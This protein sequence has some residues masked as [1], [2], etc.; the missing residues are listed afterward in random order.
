MAQIPR[1]LVT[2]VDS[3]LV[4]QAFDVSE[5]EWT[6]NVEHHHQADDLRA[7][8]VYLKGRRFV[9]CRSYPDGLPR[10]KSGS[11]DRSADSASMPASESA[12]TL[13]S[14]G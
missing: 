3:T 5:R 4:E 8:F 14:V 10:L 13:H 7:G 12:F 6:S 2:D 1:R 11:S 9:I